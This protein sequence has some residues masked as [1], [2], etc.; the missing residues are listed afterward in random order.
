M[1]SLRTNYSSLQRQR[2]VA[3]IVMM[4]ILVLGTTT[5]LVSSLNSASLQI[6]RDQVT[7]NAL[8]QAK[9]ALIGDA[10]SQTQVNSAGYLRLPDL[11][12]VISTEGNAAGAF[13]GNSKDY[14][15][16]G[17]A[18]WKTL[19]IAPSRD[20]QGECLWYVV[21][22][23]FKKTPKTDVA[24]N[25][26][27]QG[28]LDV[29][30]G[31][32]NVIASNIAAL[33][34]APGIPL[35]GQ[36]RAL[37][38]PAYAQC[39][40]N[41]NAQNY[42]D[43]FNNAD[44]ITG[45]VNYFTGSTNNRVALNT[46][47]KRFVYA[48]SSHYNDRLLYVTVDDIFRPIIRRSDFSAQLSALLDDVVFRTHLQIISITGSKGT[49][50]VD[51]DVTINSDNK[52]FC[53]N[54]KEMLLLTRLPASS[55]I[56]IDGAPTA[57]CARVLIFGGKKTTAQARLTAADKVAPA[58]YLEGSNLAAF[59]TPTAT[60]SDFSGASTFNASSPSADLMRCLP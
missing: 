30:D 7:A 56:T 10:V 32:G 21:S 6:T 4:L 53:E 39:G 59:A 22:G 51:C 45:E 5:I 13:A 15:V 8:A 18:P 26:D 60:A 29:I 17:K 41:Y 34:V 38:D 52:K 27:T 37:A 50:N 33:L 1:S 24:F 42:L 16:I 48:Q 12:P 14:S 47:N 35:D 2:G 46:N 11:G 55:P 31:N 9:E 3:F 36:N 20:G 57:A 49:N 44:A 25:W 23:R 19:G 28:Q 58:N 43:S 40:G 54:W